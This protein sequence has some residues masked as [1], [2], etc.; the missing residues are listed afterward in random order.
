MK[1]TVQ[2]VTMIVMFLI[3]N[4]GFA[5]AECEDPETLVFSI[6][7]T[8][9]SIQ[10]VTIYKPLIDYL[11][12]MTGKKIEVYVPILYENVIQGMTDK[13]I[14]VAILGPYS[15]VIANKR[16]SNIQVFATY[17]KKDRYL[18]EEG[19]GYRS[20]LI[21]KKNSGFVSIKSLQDAVVGFTD[22]SST[23]GNLIP[24]V[25]FS[26]FINAP[27]EEYFNNIIYTGGHDLSAMSVYDGKID[28][29]FVATHRLDNV[30]D[31]GIVK[32][33]D[34]N[35]LWSSPVIPQDPFCYRKSLCPELKKN[36]LDTFLTLHT[37]PTCSQF[38]ININSNGFMKMESEDYDVI[39]K[40]TH[41]IKNAMPGVK[42]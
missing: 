16:D 32:K 27:V 19:P 31:R 37:Q 8:E 38:L 6:I 2:F 11:G 30:I 3:L 39:R 14:D 12:R 25:V 20:V 29:A 1:K 21:T 23:S 13:W 7:P 15:Y 18:Q 40:L 17:I 5:S 10:E 28:A 36:I 33:E 34:F 41:K 24:R 22:Q 42:F 26:K 4:V 35:Y 9:E